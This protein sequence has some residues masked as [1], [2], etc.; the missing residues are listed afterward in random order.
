M[1]PDADMQKH[2]FLWDRVMR[3]DGQDVAWSDKERVSMVFSDDIQMFDVIGKDPIA[4]HAFIAMTH[5]CASHNNEN[6]WY[7]HICE[8]RPIAVQL[9]EI[10]S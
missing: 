8:R 9:L 3:Y 10:V 4:Y 2:Q 1:Y 6:K 5:V 7:I